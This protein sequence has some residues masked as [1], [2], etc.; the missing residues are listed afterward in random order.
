MADH[1]KQSDPKGV[2]P[3]GRVPLSQRTSRC[4]TS[5]RI[6]AARGMSASPHRQAD[7][8]GDTYT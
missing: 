5:L 1:P 8:N 7:A 2:N 6:Q 3:T 4:R